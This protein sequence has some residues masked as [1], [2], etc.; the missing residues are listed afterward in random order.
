[1]DASLLA[2][3]G[4]SIPIAIGLALSPLPI[5]AMVLA[6][7]SAGGRTRGTFLLLGRVLALV[8][9][10]AVVIGA[11][12]AITALADLVS[13]PPVVKVVLGFALIVFGIVKWRPK[14]SGP[15]ALPGWMTTLE[16]ASPPKAFGL[17]FLLTVANPKELGLLTAAG[18]TI[19]GAA[20]T[21]PEEIVVALAVVF[22]ACLSIA[23][24]LLAAVVAP[25]W[26]TP[27]L[28]TMRAWLER[29]N[30]TIMAI[31]LIVIGAIVAGGA[32]L[33]L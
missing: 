23:I 22:V 24:P 10:F 20:L 9:V 25:T 27:R 26:M 19:G 29:N 21:I 31:L 3:I 1:M 15:A 2:T 17:G 8:V 4:L 13:L 12:D 11:S 14:A 30:S 33:N 32:L 5:I 6:L 28:Q 18:V 16:T 7:M